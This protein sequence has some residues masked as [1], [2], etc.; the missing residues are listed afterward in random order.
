MLVNEYDLSNFKSSGTLLVIE[1]L[2]N[3]LLSH[4]AEIAIG[5]NGSDSNQ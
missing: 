4:D 3:A 2:L 1:C 5:K